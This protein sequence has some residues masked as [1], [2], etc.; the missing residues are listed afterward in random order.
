MTVNSKEGSFLFE[1]FDSA[2]LLK[3][4]THRKGEKRIGDFDLNKKNT[5]FVI[6]GIQESIGPLANNG[7]SGSENAF[8]SFL[9]VFLN[10]QVHEGFNIDQITILG[11][12]KFT[13]SFSSVEH[14]SKQVAELDDFVIELLNERVLENQIPIVIGGGHNNAYPLIKWR[15]KEKAINVLNLDPHAD[16]REIDR[17]HSGN[18]F[19]YA[20]DQGFL[21]KYAVL[22]LHEAFNNSFIRNFLVGQR[23]KHS[24]YEDYLVGNRN[25]I[26]DASEI[27]QSWNL[28]KHRIGIEIDMDS[29]ANM[30]S[31]A[32][33]P[34]GWSLD[35]VRAYLMRTIPQVEQLAYV[36]LPEAAPRNDLEHKLVGK[37]LTYLVRDVVNKA[38]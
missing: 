24:Y 4:F 16:C 33:S 34:S 22:G 36:H 31:S 30:P 20:I 12:I 23:I 10:S 14:A 35:E 9:R 28:D 2:F 13:S 3:F 5:R 19:S 8:D 17:R 38:N 37:A 1:E 29:I 25:L 27:I 6:L 11:S 15:F 18:S 21:N 32:F 7:F 26:D